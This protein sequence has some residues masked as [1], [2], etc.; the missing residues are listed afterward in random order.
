MFMGICGNDYAYSVLKRI[1][2]P[3]IIFS[4][5]FSQNNTAQFQLQQCTYMAT[6]LRICD[7]AVLRKPSKFA[8]K[9]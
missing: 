4:T 7:P 2:W 9:F 1:P 8:C 5:C 3:C 6:Y